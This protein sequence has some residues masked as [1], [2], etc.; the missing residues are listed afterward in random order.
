MGVLEVGAVAPLFTGTLLDIAF[1]TPI[2]LTDNPFITA[3]QYASVSLV[4]Q[5][6]WSLDDHRAQPVL[7]YYAYG[8]SGYPPDEVINRRLPAW[9]DHG[10]A[11]LVD[12]RADELASIV[13]VRTPT[14]WFIWS[15]RAGGYSGPI[16]ADPL[17]PQRGSDPHLWGFGHQHYQSWV[18]LDGEGAVVGGFCSCDLGDPPRDDLL[19]RLVETL[20]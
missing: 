19:V 10:F 1:E 9:E 14:P 20:G 2:E 15:V 8:G 18:L 17:A 11:A 12:E 5:G 7:V 4:E 16:I 3:E 6:T 13:V